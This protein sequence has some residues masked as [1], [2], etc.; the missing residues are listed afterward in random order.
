MLFRSVLRNGSSQ[1]RPVTSGVPQGSITGPVLFLLYVNDLP[2]TVQSTAK[3]FADDTKLYRTTEN[4][5]DCLQ[6]QTDLNSLAA[7]SRS[8]LLKFNEEKCVVLRIRHS[9]NFMYTLNGHPLE[10]VSKHKD[11]GIIITDNLKPSEHTTHVATRGIHAKV[12][13]D[14]TMFYQFDS[15]KAQNIVYKFS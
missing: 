14:S 11:L 9:I 5:S 7:W 1:W 2:E 10:Q 3:L 8:W 15:Y 12:G 6:L 13:N 4:L